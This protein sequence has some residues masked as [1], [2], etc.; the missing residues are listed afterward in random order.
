MIEFMA[1]CAREEFLCL[2]L[3]LVHIQ[4]VVTD[5]DTVGA[6]DL[7]DLAGDGQAAFIAGLLAVLLDDLGIDHGQ[8]LILLLCHIDDNN[9]LQDTDLGCRKADAAGLIHCLEHILR[10]CADTGSHLLD[11]FCLFFEDGIAHFSDCAQCHIFP[12]CYIPFWSVPVQNGLI[13]SKSNWISTWRKR[14]EEIFRSCASVFS[15]KSLQL[16]SVSYFSD[17]MYRTKR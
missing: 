16:I 6:G 11:D 17:F 8:G 7:A 9:S 4:I 1:D 3:P 13:G 15:I 2:Q 12:F 14:I 10:E 5:H